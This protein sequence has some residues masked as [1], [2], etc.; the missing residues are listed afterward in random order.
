MPSSN[1][2]PGCRAKPARASADEILLHGIRGI[3]GVEIVEHHGS[4]VRYRAK[5]LSALT[6]ARVALVRAGLPVW[7]QV[8]P[9][10]L[11]FVVEPR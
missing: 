2:A 5:T 7:V 9:T 11:E 3:P 8:D 10:T 6:E 1:P 4:W